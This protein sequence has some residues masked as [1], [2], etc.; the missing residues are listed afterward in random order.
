VLNYT[1]VRYVLERGTQISSKT[2]CFTSK[3]GWWQIAGDF[4]IFSS[5]NCKYANPTSNFGHLLGHAKTTSGASLI[6]DVFSQF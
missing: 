6:K 1:Y 5:K 4:N 2:Y 3:R